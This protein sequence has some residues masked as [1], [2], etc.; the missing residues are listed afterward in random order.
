MADGEQGAMGDA[1]IIALQHKIFSQ[2]FHRSRI[3]LVKYLYVYPCIGGAACFSNKTNRQLATATVHVAIV[4]KNLGS[5]FRLS[6]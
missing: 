3:E 5:D 1:V 2:K 4:I 6:T